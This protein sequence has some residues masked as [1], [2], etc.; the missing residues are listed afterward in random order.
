VIVSLL[1]PR[2]TAQEAV[3]QVLKARDGP[4]MD[5][6]PVHLDYRCSYIGETATSGPASN[7][8]DSGDFMLSGLL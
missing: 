5:G 3:V 6:S 7:A 1:R 4:T 2:P 8:L